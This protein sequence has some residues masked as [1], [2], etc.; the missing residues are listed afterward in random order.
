MEMN[1]KWE[2]INGDD[3]RIRWERVGITVEGTF[4]GLKTVSIPGIGR[5]T[6]VARFQTKNGEQ[7][8]YLLVDLER[9]LA[10]IEIGTYVHIEYACDKKVGAGTLKKFEVY[11]M[12]GE[13]DQTD[14]DSPDTPTCTAVPLK[15]T[16]PPTPV[17]EEE[18]I[19]EL[20]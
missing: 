6:K 9:K 19:L 11:I 15:P 10:N 7:Y 13:P 18:P 2:K 16:P 17:S 4:L 20:F 5:V 12:R 14:K 8:C 1:G 3:G